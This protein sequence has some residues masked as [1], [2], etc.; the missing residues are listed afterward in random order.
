MVKEEEKEKVA[1]DDKYA[2]FSN[3]LHIQDAQDPPKMYLTR[4][5]GP[6]TKTFFKDK[7]AG[8]D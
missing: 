2:E 5:R 3:S 1:Q 7:K 4:F 8:F 6:H